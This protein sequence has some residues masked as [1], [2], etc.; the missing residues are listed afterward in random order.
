MTLLKKTSLLELFIFSFLFRTFYLNHQKIFLGH[1]KY[2]LSFFF[3]FQC[4]CSLLNTL[5]D[6]SFHVLTTKSI[7]IKDRTLSIYEGGG[8]GFAGGNVRGG[9]EGLCRGHEIC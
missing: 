4:I 2:I 6:N 9:L 3:I 7:S 8:G 5:P 1:H